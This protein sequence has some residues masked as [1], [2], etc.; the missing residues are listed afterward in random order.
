MQ[1]LLDDYAHS[2]AL[3]EVSP[4]LK[5]LL[6]LG[7]LLICISSA[8]PIAPM[9]VVITMSLITLIVAKIPGS[10][11][12]K[13]LL[14]PISFAFLSSAVVAFLHGT[15]QQIFA[16]DL[17]GLDLILR[18]DGANLALLLIARTLGGICSLLFLALTTPIIEIF[19]VLKSLRMPQSSIELSMMIYRY[20]FVFLDQATKIH[21]AQIMRLGDLGVKNSISSFA[22]LSSVLFLR[23][24]EQGERLIIAMDARCNDG[25]LDLM[26][27]GSKAEPKAI[28][29]VICYIIVATAIAI[30]TRDIQLL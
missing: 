12:S 4:W 28:L 27:A 29:M 17:W 16:A 25:K 10:L 30:F 7:A 22:M 24:W 11:Y 13:L 1:D 26:E 15:G 5:L 21:S 20:I 8:T 2:N 14:I 23:A 3:R 9:F 19:A 6:C 18:A